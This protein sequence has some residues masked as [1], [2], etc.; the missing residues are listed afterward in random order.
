MHT[1]EIPEAKRKLYYI[2]EDLSECDTIQ[3]INI[4]KLLFQLN[5]GAINREQFLIQAAKF[6]ILGKD[7]KIDDDNEH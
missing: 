1:I 5:T 3:Y 2:P 7:V 4:S 6:L